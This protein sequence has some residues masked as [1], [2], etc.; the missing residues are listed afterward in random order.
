MH[1]LS[2]IVLEVSLKF[3]GDFVEILFI[4]GGIWYTG[5]NYQVITTRRSA[6]AAIERGVD[7]CNF[8]P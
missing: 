6:L 2:E 1:N 4:G 3:M 8:T 5:Y 7:R